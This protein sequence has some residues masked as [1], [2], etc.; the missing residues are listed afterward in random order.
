MRG[1]VSV[2]F[3]YSVAIFL[4]IV[5]LSFVVSTIMVPGYNV[6]GEVQ[7]NIIAKS[8][9][10]DITALWIQEE[11]EIS[12]E[13]Q[14]EWDIGFHEKAIVARYGEF[15]SEEA[16]VLGD[17]NADYT[18]LYSVSKITIKKE[19]GKITLEGE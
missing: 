7:A 17:V 12:R 3:R 1:L 13:L 4:V 19:A 6:H 11:G 2:I 8:I 16:G 9:A 15:E 14:G 18:D 5:I 10:N